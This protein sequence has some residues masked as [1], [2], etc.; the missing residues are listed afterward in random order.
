MLRVANLSL[1]VGGFRLD[2]VSVQIEPGEYFVLMGPTG[3][4]KSLLVKCICGLIRAAGGKVFLA[5]E[6]VTDLEPRRRRIGYV[7]QDCGLFPHMNVGKNVTFGLRARGMGRRQA[8]RQVAPLIDELGLGPLLD[9]Q[10]NT[11][12]GGERQKVAVARALAIDPGL[13]VLDEPV[14][15]LDGFSRGEVCRQLRRVQARSGIATVHVCHFV[16]EARMVADRVGVLGGGR[17]IQTGT[18]DD[19]LQN[20]AS[21]EVGR[22]LGVLGPPSAP[23]P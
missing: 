22:L 3:S 8:I 21:A 9:R 15:S 4:G 16:D 14:S 11:L 23:E 12:S 2:G 10:P 17:L 7:P 1:R 19:I 18:L 20:P 5:N 13:L 6:D